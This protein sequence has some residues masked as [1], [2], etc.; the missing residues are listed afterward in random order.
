MEVYSVQ[1]RFRP[2][3]N[4][5]SWAW[6]EGL[7]NWGLRDDLPPYPTPARDLY[8]SR[9]W[10]IEPVLAGAIVTQTDRIATTEWYLRGGR[11][12]AQKYARIFH[13][14]EGGAGWARLIT[15]LYQDYLT[16]NR[17]S[18]LELGRSDP[19]E[20]SGPVLGLQH[21]DACR[22]MRTGNPEKPWRYLP[23]WGE[24]IDLWAE[25]VIQ[26]CSQPSGRD[27]LRGSG[28]CAVERL[29][30]SIGLM[31]GWLTHDQQ[32]LGN[33]PPE[34]IAIFNGLSF[35]KVQKSYEAYQARRKALLTQGRSTTPV[36][37]GFWM[38][39]S[40]NPS[41][42]VDV[43][44]VNLRRTDQYD[45][46]LFYEWWIKLIALN[47]Q[48]SVSQFW[49]IQHP[50]AT[51]AVEG[52]QMEME[53]G[54]GVGRWAQEFEWQVNWKVLP[55][56]VRF[57]F[58]TQDDL[59][60]QSHAEILGRNVNSLVQ[61]ASISD[62]YGE[63]LQTL[64]ELRALAV[65]WGI[66][67]ETAVSENLP[68][69]VGQRLKEL[70]EVTTV[71]RCDLSTYELP[72]VLP[73][74]WRE[75]FLRV[76]EALEKAYSPAALE[77]A[78]RLAEARKQ[79]A[80]RS[81]LVRKAEA[82]DVQGM[83]LAVLYPE[84][85]STAW[86]AVEV[87]DAQYDKWAAAVVLAPD[88]QFYIVSRPPLAA[89]LDVQSALA[90]KGSSPDAADLIVV[91]RGAVYQVLSRSL[92]ERR[93]LWGLVGAAGSMH[94]DDSRT[95]EERRAQQQAILE[96]LNGGRGA[97]NISDID[98]SSGAR[99]AA[100]REAA[101]M[102]A[103]ESGL[104]EDEVILALRAWALTSGS[105]YLP[106]LEVQGDAARVFG[107]ELS[108]RLRG[109]LEY[110]RGSRE[111]IVTSGGS[112]SAALQPW[113]ERAFPF[114]AEEETQDAQRSRTSVLR[115]E[116]F[117]RAMYYT[118]QRELEAVGVTH[119]ELYRGI[120]AGPDGRDRF[121]LGA[122]LPYR[123]N[124]LES[125]SL[126]LGTARAY[127]DVVLRTVVPARRVLSTCRTGFGSLSGYEFVVLGGT[128]DVVEV[129]WVSSS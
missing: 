34:A 2:T 89:S 66:L 79:E 61:L 41:T 115:S 59:Q 55:S 98:V 39:G 54:K 5:S 7:L 93:V 110:L 56:G 116:V 49:L 99:L 96:Y 14:A 84:P 70:G 48:A 24:G 129:A 1:P 12:L 109:K 104:P 57:Y 17:G 44:I 113:E 67:P 71:V 32:M 126:S 87:L 20:N 107:V 81:W 108:D 26:I 9:C 95:T 124:P 69:I 100:G 125:W 42:P 6:V 46:N 60:D 120:Q 88:G 62:A 127:G 73:S 18:M 35:D 16:T 82:L 45:R 4:E 76:A 111:I 68:T 15:L 40:D 38:M 29:R 92:S 97:K 85:F 106:S 23:E 128:D 43:K 75:R 118:T 10:Q 65:E 117:L 25:N 13:Q 83:K 30:E 114:Q 27:H 80:P 86:R 122:R 36:Y 103:Q 101:R 8:L 119:V 63:P 11:N 64:D 58:D 72:P 105:S 47:L 123:A 121:L 78:R 22:V 112:S 91:K 19:N 37:A 52:I 51:K 90:A 50:G 31:V 94:P 3:R 53:S 28:L 102:I 33:L 21:L 74:R 77:Q